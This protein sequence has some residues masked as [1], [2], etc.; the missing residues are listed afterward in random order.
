MILY[1]FF[2][3]AL[4]IS[5][6]FTPLVSQ[7]TPKKRG[8]DEYICTTT[9]KARIN[10]K[11]D[12]NT[13][14]DNTGLKNLSEHIIECFKINRKIS[15]DD[16]QSIFEGEDKNF[17]KRVYDVLSIMEGFRII[18]VNYHSLK[19]K[20]KKDHFLL[21][22]T[23]KKRNLIFCTW[24]GGLKPP[25]WFE[26]NEIFSSEYCF[27]LIRA[28]KDRNRHCIELMITDLEPQ[29]HEI[30]NKSVKTN[31][32]INHWL[33]NT[34]M[35]HLNHFED[36]IDWSNTLK[37]CSE[38]ISLYL[39]ILSFIAKRLAEVSPDIFQSTHII[40]K[41]DFFIKLIPSDAKRP[42]R[43][44][45][46]MAVLTAVG[47]IK[48]YNRSI[49]YMDFTNKILPNY[50]DFFGFEKAHFFDFGSTFELDIMGAEES[51]LEDDLAERG[52]TPMVFSNYRN[53]Q[54]PGQ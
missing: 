50:P 11:E 12:S 15:N 37:S 27:P 32:S 5:I 34:A 9:K 39:S 38:R 4:V 24:K 20:I 42:R 40:I 36:K 48:K 51:T 1:H 18:E 23:C 33:C 10:K 45:D 28:R 49:F 13:I 44:Y 17:L 54:A 6:L 8:C 19:T 14:K 26:N 22:N 21:K 7:A 52:F 41:S 46:I 43:M 2:Y 29:T 25:C 31:E 35:E 16:L 3:A 30:T 47:L 53:G